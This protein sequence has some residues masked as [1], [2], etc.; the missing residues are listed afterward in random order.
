MI[1]YNEM[2]NAEIK[3]KLTELENEYNVI[4]TKIRNEIDRMSELN[5]QYIEGS[6]ILKKRT[7]GR[8]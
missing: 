5:K 3:I 8:I 6:A 7:R 2:S 4:Q 1:N